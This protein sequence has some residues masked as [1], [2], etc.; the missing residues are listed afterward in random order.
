MLWKVDRSNELVENNEGLTDVRM[1]IV[2]IF[3]LVV[4]LDQE[5]H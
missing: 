4:F 3:L 1:V 5:V 2:E